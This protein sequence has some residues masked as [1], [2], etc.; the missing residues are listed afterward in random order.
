[1]KGQAAAL[2]LNFRLPKL[3]QVPGVGDLRNKAHHGIIY[4]P[5]LMLG[6]EHSSIQAISTGNSTAIRQLYSNQATL[7]QS[8]MRS[9]VEP[10]GVKHVNVLNKSGSR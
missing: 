3:Q 7:Q 6:R 10:G 9:K 8:G 2:L 1:M 4:S 5:V